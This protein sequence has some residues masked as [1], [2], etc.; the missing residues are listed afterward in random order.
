VGSAQICR[1][2]IEAGIPSPN[3]YRL[4]KGIVKDK[5]Y[6]K[7]EWAIP[8]VK[9]ILTC[10]VYL[11]H[12]EQGR[13]RGALYEGGG[14]KVIGRDEWTVVHN[15]HEPIVSQE[16][17][18]RANAVINERTAAYKA[19]EGCYAHIEKPEML[20]KDLVFCADCGRPLFRYKSVKKKY[21]RVYWIYQCR[22]HNNLMNCPAKYIHEKNLY[23]A[24]YA[25]IRIELQKCAD[26]YGII[27][28]LN[29]EGGH[30]TK[31]ARYDAEIEEAERELR[32]IS[33]LR[34]AVYDDYAAKLLTASEYQFASDKYIS[35]AE[36]NRGRLE[37]AKR[38]KAEYA[39][40]STPANKWLAA[41][42]R[43]MDKKE[44]TADFA[45][46]LIE[47]VEVSS[48]DSVKV[49]FKFKDECAAICEAADYKDCSGV[50]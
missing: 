19:Q 2:L 40:N 26:V 3:Q 49:I 14:K 15:T 13:K 35:D 44:L 1:R 30:K 46:A 16:L 48:R 29:R 36:K 33:S 18:D 23:G 27:E 21:D 42:M 17:F 41:F 4:M 22:S 6:E 9:R 43:F 39:Q 50:A 24:V 34:Q 8:V 45:Q 31:L 11:G 20:L 7:S 5:K 12:M 10:Q 25:A 28:K 38:D 37:A 47:R 32:R